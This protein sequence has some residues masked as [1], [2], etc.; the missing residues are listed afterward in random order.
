MRYFS[1]LSRRLLLTLP[2][3]IACTSVLRATTPLFVD[4]TAADN[5][6]VYW[7]IK[8]QTPPKIDGKLNDP[9]WKRAKK[10]TDW[11]TTDYGRQLVPGIEL[12]KIDFRAAWDDH[13]LYV[14]ARCYH[15]LNSNDMKEFLRQVGDSTKAIYA[16]EC[17]EIHID[18]NLDHAT[19]F[20]AI[21]NPL[22]ERMMLWH[23]D[24]GWGIL[25]NADYGLDA[26][27]DVAGAIQQDSWTV[28]ARF[29]L[30]DIQVKPKIGY[31][32]GLNPCWFDWADSKNRDG[33]TY[34]FQYVT[35]STHND[36]HHDPRLF[37][38]F[39]LVNDEPKDLTAGLRLAF[40]DLEKR[41]LM[42][43]TPDGYLVYRHGKSSFQPYDQQVRSEAKKARAALD[44]VRALFAPGQTSRSG[45]VQKNVLPK[46][47]AELKKIEQTLAAQKKLTR[48]IV[49]TYRKSLAEINEKLDD[50][51]WRV[52][53]DVLLTAISKNNRKK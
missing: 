47:E 35:W 9:I 32:F 28:E 14:A 4:A 33:K 13:Y 41:A 40:P 46:Q 5:F 24:F 53:Q 25:T 15:P 37:G 45:Y 52:K 17:I 42:I 51:Y 39:I 20:Q 49:N 34:W 8:A 2:A 31:M 10:L 11:G 22:G 7:L 3:L 1:S 23:Y 27:W 38:R 16:R 26:D 12:G 21:V 43:Q 48:K 29:A 6:K 19:T 36:S 18:G 30:A 50:L 44:R